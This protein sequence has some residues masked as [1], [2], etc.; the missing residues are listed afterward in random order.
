MSRGLYTVRY[1]ALNVR[2]SVYSRDLSSNNRADAWK[3]MEF[4]RTQYGVFRV[5]I[6]YGPKRRPSS[7]YVWYRDNEG[8]EHS[9]EQAELDPTGFSGMFEQARLTEGVTTEPVR[10]GRSR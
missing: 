4:Q 8:V 1:W 9:R 3:E 6:L 7:L 5:E 2:G 10:S